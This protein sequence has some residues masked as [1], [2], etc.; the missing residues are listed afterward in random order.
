[1]N[2]LTPDTKARATAQL[3]ATSNALGRRSERVARRERVR[4][5]W[6]AV[7]D[8]GAVRD[9]SGTACGTHLA[10]NRS[11]ERSGSDALTPRAAAQ[12]RGLL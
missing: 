5:E 7:P 8:G 3:P 1:M 11:A 9:R 12:I 6:A 10:S 4:R 2:T